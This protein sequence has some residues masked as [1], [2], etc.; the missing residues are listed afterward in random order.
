MTALRGASDHPLDIAA[1]DALPARPELP[2]REE[3]RFNWHPPLVID[4][5]LVDPGLMPQGVRHHPGQLRRRWRQAGISGSSDQE[6]ATTSKHPAP[7]MNN[8]K[9]RM[10]Q[11]P[12]WCAGSAA[13][14]SSTQ[15][16]CST[17]AIVSYAPSMFHAVHRL[18][19]VHREARTFS[20]RTPPR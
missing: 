14:S 13:W 5:Q 15:S 1:I 8:M 16:D 4:L 19:V 20:K 3:Q 6:A 10:A 17:S 12:R 7:S 9:C 18:S 2:E 11:K